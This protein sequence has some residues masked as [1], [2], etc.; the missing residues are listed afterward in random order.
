MDVEACDLD[1]VNDD[2]GVK[3][4]MPV[5]D[6]EGEAVDGDHGLVAVNVVGVELEA[7]AGDLETVGEGGVELIELDAAVEAGAEGF[8][9]FGFEQW[10]GAMQIDV[11]GDEGGNDEDDDDGADPEKSD[12][13]RVMAAAPRDGWGYGFVHGSAHSHHLF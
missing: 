7:G 5:E 2:G 12:H 4:L 11:A 1:V 9:D 10:A 3:K 6:V 13:E 8:N